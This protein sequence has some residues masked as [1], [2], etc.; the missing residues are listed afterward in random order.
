MGQGGRGSFFGH[1]MAQSSFVNLFD[2]LR[3]RKAKQGTPKYFG[4]ILF[5]DRVS[6]I[7][8][9][10]GVDVYIVRRAERN[11]WA[12]FMCP[13]G[14]GHRLTVNLS[15]NRHP[16]WRAKTKQQEFSLSPSIWLKE[17]CYGHFWIEDHRVLW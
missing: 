2:W 8:E 7:P 1:D 10:I 16:Y 15:T 11:I 3:K 5:V 12:V 17:D 9:A 14:T 13:C 4:K 6:E